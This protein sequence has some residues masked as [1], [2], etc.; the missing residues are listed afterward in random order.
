MSLVIT[1]DGRVASI[2]ISRAARMLGVSTA[3][4]RVW[5]RKGILVPEIILDRGIRV[6]SM[7]QIEKLMKELDAKKK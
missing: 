1:S 7:A 4:L 5:H 6:Y 2:Q 3:T